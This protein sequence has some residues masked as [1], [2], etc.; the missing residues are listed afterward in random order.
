MTMFTT[1]LYSIFFFFF[2][3]FARIYLFGEDFQNYPWCTAS[4]LFVYV[5]K[6]PISLSDKNILIFRIKLKFLVK[7]SFKNVFLTAW[8]VICDAIKQNSLVW[9]QRGKKMSFDIVTFSRK[10]L[11]L[12][13]RVTAPKK[14]L[15]CA[16][17]KKY[18]HLFEK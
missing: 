10:A 6:I 4:V 3:F 14:L 12:G 16:L 1:S 13:E 7:N 2:Y 9:C 15:F 8:N 11:F 18:Q 17:S 5:L